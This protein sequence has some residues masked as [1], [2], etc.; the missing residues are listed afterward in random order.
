MSLTTQP[1]TRALENANPSALATAL[2]DD[3]AF[4]TPILT[5]DLHGK[6]LALRFLEQAA[7]TITGLTYYDSVGDDELR[8]M[9]WRGQMTERDIEGATIIKTNDDGLVNDLTVLMRSW[10]VV[11]LFRDAMLIALA[12]AVPA[13]AWRL[14]AGDAPEPDPDADA[15]RSTA[16]PLAPGVRFH[17]PMLT[18]TVAGA[19]NVQKVHKLIGGI[20]GTRTYHARFESEGRR[21][22]YW[23]CVIDGHSQQG[24]DDVEINAEGQMTDQ[25]VWLRPWPVTTVLRDRAMAG[26][27]PFLGPD[28]WLLPAHPSPLA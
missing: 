21:V 26:G 27:L 2:A 15:G 9:F 11:Q 14:G 28:V 17:S 12:D 1:L 4:H 19:D 13:E 16:L 24:I 20:Q 10:S 18:K 22:E 8:I 25:K 6:E 3:V 7:K 23:T 5:Q